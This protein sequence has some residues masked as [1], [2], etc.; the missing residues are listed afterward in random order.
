M[1]RYVMF[2]RLAPDSLRDP[3]EFRAIA[4]R[5]AERLRQ[6]TSGSQMARQLRHP[7][8][9]RHRGPVRGALGRGR[10]PGRPARPV[11]RRGHDRDVPGND[12]GAF[13]AGRGDPR[14]VNKPLPPLDQ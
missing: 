4:G 8:T 10:H 13:L 3:G 2:T 7:G 6:Q 11:G 12:V 5:V 9:M 14:C 1:A